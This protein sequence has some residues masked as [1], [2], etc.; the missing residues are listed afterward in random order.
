[1]LIAQVLI[2]YSTYQLDRTFSY[3]VN[4]INVIAGARVFVD[5]NNRKTV[6]IVMEI[7]EYLKSMD[8]YEAEFGFK[9][10]PII[11]AVDD[12]VILNDELLNLA[13]HLKK[14]TISPLISCLSV[15]L[16]SKLK[17]SSSFGKKKFTIF[18]EVQPLKDEKLTPLQLEGYN[19]I[20]N[21]QPL[22]QV[23]FNRAFKGGLLNR[24]ENKD[25]IKKFKKETRYKE[26]PVKI[27]NFH[28]LTPDQKAV[29]DEI[30]N[31][32]KLV[33]LLH[34][35][36]GSGKTEIYLQLARQALEK[37]E[38]VL[39]LVPEISLTPQMIKLVKS[40][41]GDKVAI[42]HSYL[43]EQEKYEQ[44][45]RVVKNEVKLVVGTRSSIFMP[46]K[47]IGLIILDE[48]HD[49]SYKQNS[50]PRYHARDVA[51]KRA[52]SHN[53]KVILGSATP[54]LE[55]YARAVKGVYHLL[56]LPNKIG[57]HQQIPY[58]IIDTQ[59]S[60]YKGQSNILTKELI[61]AIQYRLDNN[62]QSVI[63]LNRRGYTPVFTC[64]ECQK[65]KMCK[66]CD[67]A[68]SYHKEDNMMVCHVCGIVEKMPVT[69]NHCGNNKFTY[70]GFGTQRVESELHRLFEGVS[71]VR[72]DADQVGKKG[73]H[74]RLLN[75][76]ESKGDI[77]LG[78]QMIAKGLDYHRVT[79]VGVLNADAM[80]ARNSYRSVEDT[81]NLITQVS[82]RGGRG[83]L[84]SELIVQS[85]DANHYAI[86]LACKNDYI[87]FFNQEMQY[88]HLANYPPYSFLI[89]I[90]LNHHN[91]QLLKEKTNLVKD[92]LVKSNIWR[93]LGPSPLI[94]LKKQHR[95]QF[96]LKG[97]DLEAMVDELNK[98]NIKITKLLASVKIV[99]DINP[100]EME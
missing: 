61:E 7:N 89:K 76:F 65:V 80:L 43:N 39:I 29:Y 20:K 24:L 99:I 50:M 41:F 62:Q 12:F 82:G 58:R 30:L 17:P 64:T 1:M 96:I 37:D 51:I 71:V 66:N 22:S 21:N 33:Y 79:L 28:P 92:F 15:M 72:M 70:R 47:N 63:L 86:V 27:E 8:E 81:F 87:R 23:E 40:R 38:S 26:Q 91:E 59:K 97:K 55:S 53:A 19:Y 4:D 25:L 34:G 83:D 10:N 88:R 77:L 68:M 5:F 9:L 100:M 84:Q 46:F 3:V 48:E 2:E 57:K 35:V 94:K 42:Y 6:G 67:L 52:Q 36:T 45:Q 98:I 14:T 95:N 54:A 11:S 18:V 78:T 32:N 44:Y 75:Q 93:I 85:F 73:S 74:E 90:V 56:N 60:L 49:S 69:C 31:T 16:P 13:K